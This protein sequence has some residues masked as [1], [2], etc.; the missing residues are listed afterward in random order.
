[1]FIYELTVEPSF[2]AA[3]LAADA[4][5]TEPDGVR[6]GELLFRLP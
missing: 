5:A 4:P 3:D 2:T 6:H 1:M